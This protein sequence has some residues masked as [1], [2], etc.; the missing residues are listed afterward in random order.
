M[1]QK[2]KKEQFT[3]QIHP[4]VS[5]NDLKC[6]NIYENG[7]FNLNGKLAQTLKGQAFLLAFTEDVKALALIPVEN[8][9]DAIHFPK[10]GRR[11]IPDVTELLS[12]K[13]ILF[14]AQY[15]VWFNQEENYWQGDLS[16]NPTKNH[17]KRQRKPIPK[18][19]KN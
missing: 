2:L 6:I 12:Q 10:S 14:P 7:D 1:K 11:R 5:R 16:E 8:D 19:K 13:K 3:I 4:P 17:L 9:T 18:S 15:E